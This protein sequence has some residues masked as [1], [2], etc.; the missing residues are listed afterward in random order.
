MFCQF[1]TG[2]EFEVITAFTDTAEYHMVACVFKGLNGTPSGE[3]FL[4]GVSKGTTATT[5]IDRSNFDT[6]LRMGSG[7]VAGREFNGQIAQLRIITQ[8]Y[9]LPQIL[10]IMADP[11][12]VVR[13]KGQASF[14]VPAGPAGGWAGLLSNQRNRLTYVS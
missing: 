9:A 10:A 1:A 4:D 8:A 13:L 7:G 2:A 3:L 12:G 14:L 5:T 11:L 6:A